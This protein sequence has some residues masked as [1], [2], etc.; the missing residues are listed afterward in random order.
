MF[1]CQSAQFLAVYEAL[2]DS[3]RRLAMPMPAATENEF[4]L[5]DVALELFFA[6]EYLGNGGGNKSVLSTEDMFDLKALVVSNKSQISMAISGE[7]GIQIMNYLKIVKLAFSY[8]AWDVFR[9]LSIKI[10]NY[11]EVRLD[12]R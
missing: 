6:A 3:N 12:I 2:D 9:R 1:D 5:L 11:I 10:I 8:E 7:N 4:E